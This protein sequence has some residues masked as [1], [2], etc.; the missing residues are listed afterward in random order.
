MVGEFKIFISH[1]AKD[2]EQIENIKKALRGIGVRFYLAEED[3]RPGTSISKKIKEH[4]DSSD[5]FMLVMTD[6]SLS[7][8]YFN[9]EVGYAVDAEM[10]I[11]PIA[12]GDCRP[13]GMI[14][15]REYIGFDS[16]DEKNSR[17]RLREAVLEIKDEI[18]SERYMRNAVV[19]LG[20][21]VVAK[22]GPIALDKFANWWQNHRGKQKK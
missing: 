13:S 15:D 21:A 3:P 1:S 2:I 12:V 14:V 6:I 16:S 4:I 22:Y 5:L 8:A 19:V 18:E 17:K 10:M 20:A 11:L 9:Q 7:S